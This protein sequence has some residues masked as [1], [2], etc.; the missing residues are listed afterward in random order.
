[1]FYRTRYVIRNSQL[2]LKCFVKSDLRYKAFLKS[3]ESGNRNQNHNHIRTTGVEHQWQAMEKSICVPG[4]YYTCCGSKNPKNESTSCTKC[5]C[6][7]RVLSVLRV[8][9]VR[10]C[11]AVCV[12]VCVVCCLCVGGAI[13]WQ[14]ATHTQTHTQTFALGWVKYSTE[15]Q[16]SR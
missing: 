15:A 10:V 3:E 5:V 9:P 8:L 12:C 11:I 6:V 2:K 1:M 13:A 7:P 4:T 16:I 14:G